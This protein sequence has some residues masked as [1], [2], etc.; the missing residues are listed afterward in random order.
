[1]KDAEVTLNGAL[2]IVSEKMGKKSE[3]IKLIHFSTFLYL[4]ITLA[5]I[6]ETGGDLEQALFYYEYCVKK[7]KQ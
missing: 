4:F 5:N 2:S 3:L 7:I 6:Y 1:M